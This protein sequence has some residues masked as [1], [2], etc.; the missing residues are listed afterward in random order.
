MGAKSG[1]LGFVRTLNEIERAGGGDD[2]EDAK[3]ALRASLR[4]LRGQLSPGDAYVYARHLPPAIQDIYL[5]EWTG[6][7]S[8]MGL[9]GFLS[10]VEG[11]FKD[12]GI[13]PEERALAVFRALARSKPAV[14]DPLRDRV[15]E[16]VWQLLRRAAIEEN[17]VQLR[18]RRTPPQNVRLARRA[19]VA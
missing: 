2:L 8:T 13:D 4:A 19:R 9:Y 1:F 12:E 5:E 11:H 6:R 3:L 7:P 14:L 16:D 10:E 15:S 17:L 18:L